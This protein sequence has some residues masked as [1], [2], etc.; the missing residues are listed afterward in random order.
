M[1][2]GDVK[3]MRK[4]V[5]IAVLAVVALLALSTVALVYAYSRNGFMASTDEQQMG[6]QNPQTFFW[7]GNITVPN[8]TT[9][10]CRGWGM[11]RMRANGLQWIEG[12][13]Q[14]ASLSNVTGTV[15]TEVRGMLVLNTGSGELR[16]L[17]PKDWTVGTEVV[18][19]ADLFNGTFASAGQTVTVEVLESSLFSNANLSINAMVGY[20]ATN[21]TGTQAYAV[22]PFNIQASS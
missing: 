19:R 9:G 11:P 1:L 2:H 3:K 7:W 12:L 21:A 16:V 20:E 14:N 17:L 13:S 15:V 8:N 10:L 4:N 5:K 18:N 22:L 6:M